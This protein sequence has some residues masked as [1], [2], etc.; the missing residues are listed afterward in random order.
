MHT[1]NH[2]HSLFEAR[3]KIYIKVEYC[4]YRQMSNFVTE[5]VPKSIQYNSDDILVYT[6][7]VAQIGQYE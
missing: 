6:G 3:H 5:Q 1:K 7:T 2:G 4:Q